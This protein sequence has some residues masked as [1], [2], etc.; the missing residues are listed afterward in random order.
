MVMREGSPTY[1]E[2]V[3]ILKV[4]I[5]V[6]EKKGVHKKKNGERMEIITEV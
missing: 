1:R 2:H 5:F 4:G 3:P 6:H